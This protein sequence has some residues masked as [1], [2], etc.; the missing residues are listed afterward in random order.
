LVKPLVVQESAAWS[1]ENQG[2]IPGGRENFCIGGKFFLNIFPAGL[3]LNLLRSG[4][5]AS[6][7]MYSGKQMPVILPSWK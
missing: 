6:G 2:C 7:W 1:A 5:A 3:F 4:Q